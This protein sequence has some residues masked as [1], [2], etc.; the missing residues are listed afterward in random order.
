M[1]APYAWQAAQWASVTKQV[2]TDRLPHALLLSGPRGLGKY[3]FAMVLAHGLLCEAADDT[4]TPCGQCRSCQLIKANAHPDLIHLLPEESGGAIQVDH[5]RHVTAQLSQTRHS[6]AYR[7]VIVNPAEAMNMAAM[8]ALLKTLEEPN[9]GTLLLLV[10]VEP[11]RLLPTIRSRCQRLLFSAQ[12]YEREKRDFL[13]QTVPEAQVDLL[14]ALAQH[15]PLEAQALAQDDELAQERQTFFSDFIAVR[16]EKSD[17]VQVAERH[18]PMDLS[19]FFLWFMQ[20]VQDC[21]RLQ[22]GI[23]KSVCINKDILAALERQRFRDRTQ[24]FV[25]WDAVLEAYQLYT[26]K[27]NINAQLVLEDLLFR[28]QRL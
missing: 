12:G 10:N 27:F 15:A 5:I 28:W 8:N 14:L 16:E 4:L 11:A 21:I 19:R 17:V 22:W 1:T 18:K 24:L 23:D 13:L 7:V 25:L 6:G 2:A 20:G 26:R 3:D 9:P